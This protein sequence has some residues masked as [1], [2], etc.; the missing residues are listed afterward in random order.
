MSI[1]FGFSPNPGDKN[2]DLAAMFENMG[3]MLRN[4]G[5]NTGSVDWDSA[6]DSV[7]RTIKNDV[8]VTD[9]DLQ[10]MKIA[11]ELADLWLDSATAFPQ[12]AT[13]FELLT[14]QQWVD[15]T[16]E[17]WKSIVEP[18]AEGVSGAMTGLLPNGQDGGKIEIPEEF[19]S[20]LPDEVAANLRET[21]AS[22]DF[23]ELAAPIMAMAKSMGATM[24]GTQF[25]QALANM[26]GEVLSTTDIGVPLTDNQVSG[27]VASNVNEFSKSLEID[28]SDVRIY[29]AL[30]E[31]AHTRLF[32][33]AQWLSSQILAAISAYAK[34]V[35]IDTTRIQDAI[36]GIDPSNPESIQSSITPDLFE[37]VLTDAQKQ[38]HQRL[39]QLLALIEGWVSCVVTQAISNRLASSTALDEA[40]RRRRAA[41]GPAEKLFGGLIGLE[42]RPKRMR[43]ANNLW[44]ELTE[45]KG[46]TE[47]DDI[48]QHPDLLPS[49]DDLA[50]VSGYLESQSID[51]MSELNRIIETTEAPKEDD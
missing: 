48:W 31:R 20:G 15:Q 4:A 24:Y 28:E 46:Q 32:A 7:K 51:L 47:R 26:S 5:K 19:I 49:L 38:A 14:K 35:R 37:P 30:R 45:L 34:G 29:I 44:Q 21:L 13:N 39:E 27:Y 8:A 43:E 1:P 11:T 23:A 16:F 9:R 18:V 50:D 17:S 25:G 6:R 10:T 41:G 2:N 22:T 33:N 12:S 40:F 3:R 36:A 42:L